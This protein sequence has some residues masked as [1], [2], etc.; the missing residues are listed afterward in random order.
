MNGDIRRGSAS[1]K[2]ISI[3]GVPEG[4]GYPF[5]LVRLAPGAPIFT[6]RSEDVAPVRGGDVLERKKESV[7]GVEREP[8]EAPGHPI[9]P[10]RPVQSQR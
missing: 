1:S 2:P 8:F 7:D 6:G 10:G 4:G 9:A 5:Y 3:W